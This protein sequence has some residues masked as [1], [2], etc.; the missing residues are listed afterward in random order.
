VIPWLIIGWLF[1]RRECQWR[2]LLFSVL[3]IVLLTI[4]TSLFWSGLYRFMFSSWPFFTTITVTAYVLVVFSLI[5]AIWCR[6]NF[7]HGFAHFI[8][9]CRVLE[10]MDFPTVQFSKEADPETGNKQAPRSMILE[11][12]PIPSPSGLPTKRNGTFMRASVYS[13]HNVATVKLS[14]SQPLHSET[15]QSS[16][17]PTP[18]VTSVTQR[19]RKVFEYRKAQEPKSTP[20][21]AGVERSNQFQADEV[22]AVP[23]LP[24]P[25]AEQDEPIVISR[26]NEKKRRSRSV[27][28][29]RSPSART[30]TM[31]T[32]TELGVLEI[33]TIPQRQRGSRPLPIRPL[34]RPPAL[35]AP[36]TPSSSSAPPLSRRG[37]VREPGRNH[38]LDQ[39]DLR[40]VE[41]W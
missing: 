29:G 2:F 16:L 22:P 31:Q 18:S 33:P 12:P 28:F 20:P 37:G 38:R 21:S 13:N 40:P 15:H 5:L 26:K 41:Q 17:S 36:P 3:S 4:F 32:I 35:S 34:P 27:S 30:S 7:G 10:N 14:S 6:F 11:I 19:L 39:V 25:A 24:K 23:P 8:Q 1:V 9:V